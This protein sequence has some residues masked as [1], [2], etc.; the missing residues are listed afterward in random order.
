MADYNNKNT[1][2]KYS[3][4]SSGDFDNI[5]RQNQ[6]YPNQNGNDPFNFFSDFID[7]G[8]RIDNAVS[9][10]NFSGVLNEVSKGINNALDLTKYGLSKAN[11]AI[12]N[13]YMKNIPP[14]QQPELVRKNS[15]Y[16]NSWWIFA[17]AGILLC[18]VYFSER[19]PDFYYYNPLITLIFAF[20]PLVCFVMAFLKNR[21]K[22]RF[23]RYLR[24][25]GKGTVLSTADLSSSLGI[26]FKRVVSDFRKLIKHDV[27]KQ[28]RLVEDDN[29]FILDMA[30]YQAYK[31][32]KMQYSQ[33]YTTVHNN[34]SD[35]EYEE[36]YK[37]EEKIMADTK[38]DEAYLVNETIN[39]GNAYV[40]RISELEKTIKNPRI[41]EK[42]SNLEIIVKNILSKVSKD[43]E[44]IYAIGQFI[45]Y[46]LPTTIKLLEVYS[47]FEA[48]YSVENE[49][50]GDVNKAMNDIENTL[51]TIINAFSKLLSNLFQDMAL[52]VMSDITVLKSLLNQDGL[53]DE[54]LRDIRREQIRVEKRDSYLDRLNNNKK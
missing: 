17:F 13:N 43:T 37:D 39:S 24:E 11:D 20:L 22:L 10:M 16:L 46:Y 53:I 49:R 35:T 9:N 50:D 40:A 5:N 21:M 41:T 29:L 23:T 44:K 14:A 30:T 42:I 6:R 1:K 45:N 7:V 31:N 8:K 34:E 51:D 54:G 28:G 52:D 38:E 3:S 25:F 19:L 15:L 12:K 26:S 27:F 2:G 32:N 47:E 36:Y 4:Y 18:I 33:F 48:G